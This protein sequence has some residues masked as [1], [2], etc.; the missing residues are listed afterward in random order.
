VREKTHFK[1]AKPQT[2]FPF[3]SSEQRKVKFYQNKQKT[4][5]KKILFAILFSAF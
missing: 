3:S 1:S 2:K 5:G 4:A